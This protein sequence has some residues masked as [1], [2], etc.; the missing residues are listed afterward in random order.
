MQGMLNGNV[1]T[2]IFSDINVRGQF[3]ITFSGD[4]S[5]FQG[6]IQ[7]ANGME[8]WTGV[9]VG[10]LATTPEGIM[11]SRAHLDEV[12]SSSDTYEVQAQKACRN[13]FG[14]VFVP[15]NDDW[16][17]SRVVG[18]NPFTQ[19]LGAP[20]Q[21]TQY[22]QV[23]SV[24]VA[25]TRSDPP[26]TGAAAANGFQYKGNVTMTGSIFRVFNGGAWSLWQDVRT[27]IFFCTYQIRNGTASIAATDTMLGV[28]IEQLTRPSAIPPG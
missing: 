15:T 11:R 17:T 14:A 26:P 27:S 6:G 4:G 21:V 3:Q 10:T 7:T 28:P 24:K 13:L 20:S 9:R 16:T 25:P 22:A 23:R 2:G 5:R 1:M 8:R 19:V 18:P 12:Q